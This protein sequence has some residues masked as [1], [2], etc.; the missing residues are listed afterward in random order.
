M[1]INLFSKAYM[2]LTLNHQNLEV[3][4]LSRIFV[5]ECYKGTKLLP[6][7]EKYNLVYQIRRVALSVHLNLAEGSSRKSLAERKDFLNS[8]GSIIE[9]DTAFDIIADLNYCS[10]DQMNEAGKVLLRCFKLLSLINK[11]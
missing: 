11:V 5:K 4:K 2:F 1:I 10:V 3:C 7:E 9:V 8:H 6:A